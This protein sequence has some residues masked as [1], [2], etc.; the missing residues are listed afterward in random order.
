MTSI[1]LRHYRHG[2]WA[3]VLA[4]LLALGGMLAGW[5]QA[6]PRWAFYL[7]A[8]LLI[9]VL[10]ARVVRSARERFVRE[11]ALPQF[12]KRKLRDAYPHLAQKEAELVEQGLRQFFLAC[13]RSKR[14]FV[15]M[16]SRAVDVLWHEFILHTRAY[17][18]WCQQGLGFFLHHTPAETLGRRA[19]HNDGLRRAWYWAC[20][21]EKIDPRA[22]SHLP[23]LFALDAQL[24]ITNGFFYLPDCSDIARKNEAGG[25]G[26]S[27]YC[28]TDFADASY[29]GSC[30]DFGGA[31]SSGDS[32]G[33][34]DGGDGG[35]GGG[36]CGGD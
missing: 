14:Q 11:A 32:G 1:L 30:D 22:P 21:Q 2:V 17:Q 25:S 33:D 5:W 8:T 19:K 4:W 20:Q 24:K 3:C 12:L 28:G 15:A 13:L 7:F 31:E 23:L 36:G 29:D 26:S 35:D 34:G 18:D 6:Q 16:P 10:L 27:T 9:W